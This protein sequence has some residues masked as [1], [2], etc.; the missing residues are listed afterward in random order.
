M[1]DISSLTSQVQ[2]LGQ[3]VDFWGVA[4]NVLLMFTALVT[5]LYIGS[6]LRQSTVAKKLRTAQELLLQAKDRQLSTDLRDKDVEIAGLK[7][8]TEDERSARVK[9]EA[10]VE[11]RSL[12]KK[13]QERLATQLSR[14][15][16]QNCLVVFMANDLESSNFADD[17][18]S[19]LQKAHWKLPEPLE[20]MMMREGPS[21]IWTH[22]RLENG[23]AVLS[24]GDTSSRE[25]A[26]VFVDK[27]NKLGFDTE[28]L[29]M[30]D[31]SPIPRV[32][33][34]VYHRPK[35]PQGEA[36]LARHK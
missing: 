33:I 1:S 5:V 21:P 34:W 30:L 20:M 7:K 18:V 9:I 11:W 28:K 13:Q 12:S 3:S 24:T 23:M 31:K 26:S 19:A 27:L 17:I 15:S 10:A 8:T 2:Q 25:S 36:K 29:P 22:K 4:V 35:G 14:F 6:T 16:S 32:E